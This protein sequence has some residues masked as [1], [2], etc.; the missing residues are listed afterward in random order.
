MTLSKRP[1]VWFLFAAWLLFAVGST[2][3][4][5]DKGVGYTPGPLRVWNFIDLDPAWSPNG[6]SIAY[7]HL[8]LTVDRHY[9]EIRILDVASN[10]SRFLTRGRYPS[11]SPD[12][13]KI[14]FS[15]G[16]HAQEQNGG[17]NIIDLQDNTITPLT[18][19]PTHDPS[20]SPDGS[21][22]AYEVAGSVESIWLMNSDG[23]GQRFLVDGHA[24]E[25]SPDGSRLVLVKRFSNVLP[26]DVALFSL[27]D[28]S[29][30]RLTVDSHSDYAATWSSDGHQIVWNSHTGLW[31][32]NPDGSDQRLLDALGA[33]SWGVSSSP[34]CSPAGDLIVYERYNS[35]PINTFS[36]DEVPI[37]LWTIRPDG[38][39]AK[40]LTEPR[41]N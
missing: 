7:S 38:T 3:C 4:G 16:L 34:S 23:S 8:H 13:R 11:W 25:W 1:P 26:W 14:A 24:P 33:R 27:E 19:G 2:S 9:Y 32:M 12:G 21:Q 39:G 36:I 30:A 28:S 5:E 29:I 40:R 31:T 10:T 20:W 22:I 18:S 37:S 15:N 35:Q 41:R 6:Q 17:I